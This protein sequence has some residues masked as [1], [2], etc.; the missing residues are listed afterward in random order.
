MRGRKATI[1]R[2]T[3]ETAVSVSVDIDGTGRTGAD[4]GIS[5]LDHLVAAF[6]KHAMADLEVSARSLD[7]IEHHLVE[8]TAIAIGAAV[9]GAL[10][11]RDGIARFGHASVPMDESLA[12]ATVDLVRRPY[13]KLGMELGRGRIEGV[14][15]EDLG[16][17]FQ[18]LLQNLN[19]CVHLEVRYGQNHHHMVEAAIKAL[20][21]AFRAASSP[22][23]R[24][25]GPP[26]TKGSM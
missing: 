2:E 12:E 17:F 16:H 9:D 13:W 23:A 8:D 5:F 20:A 1:K 26:S 4:T 25:E 11:G 14:S 10:G 21:V 6:G 24:Q 7:G 19:C 15:G 18:S 22:D 3:K